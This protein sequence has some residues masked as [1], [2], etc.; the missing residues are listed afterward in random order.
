MTC[1]NR[2]TAAILGRCSLAMFLALAFAINLSAAPMVYTGQVVTDVRVGSTTM[3]NATLKIIFEGDSSDILQVPVPSQECNGNGYFFYLTKGSASMQIEYQGRTRTAALNDG[4]IFVTVDDCNGG[5]GF[6][7][8]TGPNGLEPAYPLSFTMGT[9]EYAAI[10]Y[11]N[12]LNS[13]LSV[14]GTAWSCI[15]FPPQGDLGLPGT[16]DGNCTPPD[17][18]PLLSNIGDIYI[19]QPYSE[20]ECFSGGTGC[21]IASNHS[22]STNRGVFLVRSKSSASAPPP[23]VGHGSQVVYT[24]QTVADGSLGGHSFRQALVTFQMISDPRAVTSKTS[25]VDSTK[26][27]YENHSGYTTVTIDDNG[28]IT[29]AEFEQGEVFARYDTGAQVVGFGSRISPTYPV[30]LNCSSSAYPSDGTYTADC[31]RGEGWSF[32]TYSDPI[33]SFRPGILAQLSY[34]PTPADYLAWSPA[35]AALPQSLSQNTLLTGPAHTCAGVYTILPAGSYVYY[36]PTDLG[37]CANPAPHGL[38]TNRGSLYLQDQIGG[39]N[40]LGNNQIVIDESASD[41]GWDLG[42][43]GYFHVEVI[44][45]DD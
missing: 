16:A 29:T 39:T 1:L 34:T 4:Q 18:Y 35:V 25:P 44:R 37:V 2:T 15:G 31:E 26:T 9:A 27:L 22:G 3:H 32:L 11:P 33:Y 45:G 36:I 24:L 6:G 28:K 20:V 17:T 14:T 38:H 42:N 21:N 8:F 40:S 12:P 5:I 23:S 10:N 13:G 19:Y 41:P 30:A 43:S 7:S